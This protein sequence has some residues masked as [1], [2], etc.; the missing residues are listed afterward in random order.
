MMMLVLPPLTLT[1]LPGKSVIALF[2]CGSNPLYLSVLCPLV[3]RSTS[4]QATWL[5]IERTFQ[6]Q[7]RARCLAMKNQ[8]QTLSKGSLSMM[9]YLERK[10]QIADSLAENLHPISDEDLIGYILGGLDSSYASF[11]SAFMIHC[12]GATVDTLAGLLLQ[13]EARLDH[14]LARQAA[15]QLPMV[16]GPAPAHFPPPMAHK[17]SRNNT[18]PSF[19][20]P[21]TS[22]SSSRGTDQ[23]RCCLHCQ[24][25]NNPGHEAINCWQ[26]TNQTDYPS[27]RPNPREPP[28]QANV[29]NFTGLSRI[30]DPSWYF[31]IEPLIMF[32]LTSTN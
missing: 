29:A 9:D 3:A 5:T 28:R 6:A 17:V 19:N 8:L 26:C 22:T 13:G 20:S 32:P 15:T 11:T 30:I 23:R 7:T 18:Q 2:F 10:R 4:S 24:L 14:E 1:L 31:D 16:P 25:C 12:D 21:G 27:R